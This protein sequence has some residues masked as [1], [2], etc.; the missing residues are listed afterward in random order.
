MFIHAHLQESLHYQIAVNKQA[1]ALSSYQVQPFLND[2]LLLVLA[3]F[4]EI[5]T[6]VVLA[7]M[8]VYLDVV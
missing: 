2:I 1:C 7:C 6:S 4:E 8:I 5:Q 3:S